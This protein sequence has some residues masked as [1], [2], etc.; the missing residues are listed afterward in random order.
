MIPF[1]NIHTHFQ[2]NQNDV[3]ELIN[4]SPVLYKDTVPK[5]SSGIHPWQIEPE[6]IGFELQ[7]LRQIALHQNCFAIGEC[8]LDK[9]ISTHIDIQTSVFEQQLLLAQEFQKP[10]ILHCV[11]A[12]EEIIHIKN[13]LKITVPLIIH[14]YSKNQII[15][16]RLLNQGFF[17]SFG[18]N[19]IQNPKLATVFKNIP[20]DR[21]FLE[22]DNSNISIQ[23]IYAKAIAIKGDFDIKNAQFANLKALQT[24]H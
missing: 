17:L 21:F 24:K 20:N 14:G 19:L 13:K 23:E 12:F 10:V 3:F 9:R 2:T 16:N 6:K 4:Q 5:F 15:A 11:A 18:K 1:V 22:T 7:F 8:G